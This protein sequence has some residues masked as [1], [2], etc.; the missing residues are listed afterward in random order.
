[1]IVPMYLGVVK[2]VQKRYS[3]DTACMHTLND[4]IV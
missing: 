1:M 2:T 3:A 4:M